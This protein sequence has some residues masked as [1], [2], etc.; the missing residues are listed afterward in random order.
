MEELSKLIEES[1][2][3]ISD[4]GYAI[5]VRYTRIVRMLKGDVPT[6]QGVISDAHQLLSD[7]DYVQS[8]IDYNPYLKNI[9]YK[10][11]KKVLDNRE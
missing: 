5:S 11:W 4:F 6:P 8:L 3:T 2:M 7:I 9:S 10:V 1:G